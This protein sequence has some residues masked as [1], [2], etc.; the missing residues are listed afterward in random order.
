MHDLPTTSA[1]KLLF[2]TVYNQI[3]GFIYS[4]SYNSINDNKSYSF[5]SGR[6]FYNLALS[7]IIHVGKCVLLSLYKKYS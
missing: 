2:L 5:K 1:D 3:L 7:I 6:V 4:T